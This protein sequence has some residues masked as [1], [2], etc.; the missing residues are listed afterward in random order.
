M[1]EEGPRRPIP[2]GSLRRARRPR[3]DTGLSLQRHYSGCGE[4][5]T[6][7]AQNRTHN[8]GL[9]APV[10]LVARSRDLLLC[11]FSLAG[12]EPERVSPTYFFRIVEQEDGSWSCRR[13]REDLDRHPEL[14]DAIEHTTAIAREI[15]PSEVFVH[16]LDGQVQSIATI[17]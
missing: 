5:A 4:C 11:R 7:Q 8:R 1:R 14:D 3:V 9:P 2:I 6:S 12:C 15:P 16:R 17:D 10:A 13:G